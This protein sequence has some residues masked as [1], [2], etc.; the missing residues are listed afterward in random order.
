MGREIVSPAEELRRF[1]DGI[2][3]VYYEF[4]DITPLYLGYY[5]EREKRIIERLLFNLPR[6]KTEVLDVGCGPGRYA[7][8][9]DKKE[10]I[11][12]TG[13][14]FSRKVIDIANKVDYSK[15]VQF[16]IGSIITMPFRP[17]T[18]DV[19]FSFEVLEHLPHKPRSI[20]KAVKELIGVSKRGG[21]TI[22]EAPSPLHYRLD[23]L[24]RRF[25]RKIGK[26]R[27]INGLKDILST[28][29]F[30]KY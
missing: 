14:D 7:K 8:I 5:H 29:K 28:Q 6:R 16:G 1:F 23:G 18:F 12:Y 2:S 17:S 26:V 20:R 11:S 9:F 4:V 25:L 3:E 24:I 19:T 22:I 10:R 13:I 30:E 27:G 21:F 15:N